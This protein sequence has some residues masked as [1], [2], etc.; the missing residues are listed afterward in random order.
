MKR[1]Q[2]K[3]KRFGNLV[4][5]DEAGRTKHRARLWRCKCD[6]GTERNIIGS[7]LVKGH[8]KSCGCLHPN[9]VIDLT[10]KRFGKLIVADRSDSTDKGVARWRCRCDCGSEKIVRGD[11]LRRGEVR[12]CGCIVRVH[13]KTNSPE[14]RS[15][16]AMLQRCLN[17]NAPNYTLYGGRGI[18]ICDRWQHGED[19]M[20]GFQCFYEEMGTR[21]AGSS[22]D[23]YPDGNGNYEPG[24]CRW[25]SAKDQVRHRR[26]TVTVEV[27]GET[28]A[29]SEACESLGVDYTTVYRL[30]R[31][32]VS[33][34]DAVRAA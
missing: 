8:S 19:G 32:G 33:F 10:G 22:L 24:N 31:K 30:L 21:P 17:E 20:T 9:S 3:G 5:I 7:D 23:R 27:D 13:G 11:V 2:L 1:L 18:R 34:E 29:L 12:S 16:R 26:S 4:V 6:C 15:W 28:V 14:Y 25:A